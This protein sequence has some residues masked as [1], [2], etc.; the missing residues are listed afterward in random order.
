[1][2]KEIRHLFTP[3]HTNNHRPKIL[4]P[5]GLALLIAIYIV[6]NSS[7]K[8]FALYDQN[9]VKGNVLGY[10]SNIAT[11]DVISLTNQER[12][13]RG[14]PALTENSLLREAAAAK[15]A[16]MFTF[17]YWAHNNPQNGR[18]PW[19]FI[20]EAGYTYRYAGE[21]LARDFNDTPDMVAA[22]MA[23][24]SHRDNIISSR[25]QET[26][27][28]VVNG[29]LQGV[30]TTLVVQMFGTKATQQ[31]VSGT[32]TLG[33]A[34]QLPPPSVPPNQN[35]QTLKPIKI[36]QAADN[37]V[38]PNPMPPLAISKSIAL[39]ILILLSLTLFIDYAIIKRR[40]II[41][42]SSKNLAHLAFILAIIIVV[43]ITNSGGI[44]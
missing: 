43:I 31:A 3:H 26:G 18:Q 27:V 10:A 44:L 29:Q 11:G 35:S 4:H 30:E 9:L 38:N 25:Y 16:D 23:S 42:L 21:N 7:L 28:A 33:Q 39:S 41:R 12:A 20:K 13:N 22:W 8:L 40:K 36:V 1:M 32:K 6:S 37:K 34:Q 2:L 24:P 5:A 14:L 15:A 17:D 19:A